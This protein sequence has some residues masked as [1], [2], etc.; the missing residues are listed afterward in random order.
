MF[1]DLDGIDGLVHISELDW[2]RVERPSDLFKVGDEIQVQ[3]IG[4]D[5]ERE[6]V[7]LS[8]K[9][10]LPSPGSKSS[11]NSNLAM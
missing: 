9:A 7:S 10:L 11:K 6:R 8:R 5:V 1:V 3:V 4:I 2:Q